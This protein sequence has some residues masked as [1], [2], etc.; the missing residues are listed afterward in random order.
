M[1][2]LNAT[3]IRLESF[4]NEATTPRYAILSHTWGDSE[5]SCQDLVQLHTFPGSPRERKRIVE[6]HGFYKIRK[7]CAQALAHGLQYAW[8]DTCCIDKTSSA[9]L[10]EAINSMF[11]WYKRAAACYAYLDDIEDFIALR[12]G[13]ETSYKSEDTKVERQ[14]G[15]KLNESY[16]AKARWFT[17][18]WTLQE[19][20]AP[21]DVVF[22]A[23]GW[24]VLG[25]KKYMAEALADITG[26]DKNILTGA[27]LETMSVAQRMNWASKRETTKTEDLAY[28]L[29]G[30]FDVNMPLLYGEGEKAFVRLQEEI[31]KDSDDQSL[32][33]WVPARV[34]PAILEHDRFPLTRPSDDWLGQI[35]Y[36]RDKARGIFAAHPR[37][38]R[39]S[40]IIA[41]RP[42]TQETVHFGGP[43]GVI[44]LTSTREHPYAL[45]N[46]ENY[47]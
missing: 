25:R 44:D 2:L 47:S 13:G 40:K 41:P 37:E 15:E 17:R 43:K 22:F 33:A 45:T 9:D 10:S 38:F 11:K 16:L 42:K 14:G 32:F 5:V 24:K 26:I 1:R 7:C 35:H 39:I 27:K 19:L 29:L 36:E 46:K 8:V 6:S 30:I 31:M 23:K 3:T 4:H 34:E 21:E 12:G 18:G 20:V 28:C